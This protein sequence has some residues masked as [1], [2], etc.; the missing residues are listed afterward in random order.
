[1]C[2]R[3]KSFAEIKYIKKGKDVLERSLPFYYLCD[4][5]SK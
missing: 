2:A 5:F 1:M 3:F 4:I